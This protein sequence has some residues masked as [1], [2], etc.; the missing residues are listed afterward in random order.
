MSGS[1]RGQYL[2]LG[3]WMQPALFAA[4]CFICPLPRGG[5]EKGKRFLYTP[6]TPQKNSEENF[7]GGGKGGSMGLGGQFQIFFE[8]LP[9]S[10]LA[11]FVTAMALHTM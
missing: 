4:P 7:F 6:D 11:L 10:Y 2:G 5:K 8:Q 3:W 9:F 1:D